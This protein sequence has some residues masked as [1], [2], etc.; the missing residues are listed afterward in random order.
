MP[1][2]RFAASLAIARSPWDVYE[3]LADEGQQS[4]WR[5]RFAGHVPIVE[6][7]PYT[8]IALANNLTFGIEPGPDGGT[9]LS[10]ERGYESTSRIGLRLFGRKAQQEELLD[11]LKRIEAS[12]LYDAI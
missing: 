9:L 1:E 5:D 12:L 11:T 3:F 2:R 4:Q 10:V 7:R 6:T 8:H